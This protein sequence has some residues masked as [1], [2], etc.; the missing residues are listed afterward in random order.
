MDFE[1]FLKTKQHIPDKRIP[2]YLHWITRYHKFC[3]KY[4]VNEFESES[5]KKYLHELGKN[6]E[7][8]QV[9]QA[10]EAVRLYNYFKSSNQFQK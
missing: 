4:N 1:S 6:Y 7:D 2:Y 5:L 3:N 9:L 8:W 10:K